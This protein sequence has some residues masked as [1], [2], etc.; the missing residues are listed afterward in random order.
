M[1]KLIL[2]IALVLFAST[3]LAAPVAPQMSYSLNGL[4]ITI[5]WTTVPDAATYTLHYAVYPYHAGDT[6]YSI[7][8]GNNTTFSIDLWDGAAYYIAVSAGNS[9]GNSGYSNI[10][11]FIIS[12]NIEPNFNL[13]ATSSYHYQKSDVYVD[14][15]DLVNTDDLF[16][17]HGYADFNQD[18]FTDVILAGGIFQE[19]IFS[20]VSLY[21]NDGS[22]NFTK[23]T[24]YI[25]DGFK[26]MQHP[27]KVIVGDYNNDSRM[28]A[29]IVGHGYDVEPYPGES[30]VLLL[31]TG[32]S[33]EVTIL[34]DHFS[35][36]H[37]ASSADIDNDGDIDIFTIDGFGES[38]FLIN[39]GTGSFE[40]TND[41]IDTYFHNKH[42][43]YTTELIDVDSDGYV[44][45]LVGGHEHGGATT[46]VLWGNNTGKYTLD[47]STPIP[48]V[49]D[50][51]IVVDFDA[52][53]ID[54]DGDRDLVLN[55]VAGGGK[56]EFYDGYYVQVL[57]NTGNRQF[58]DM[59]SSRITNGSAVSSEGQW[60]VG[61]WFLWITMEDIDNDGDLDITTQDDYVPYK[62]WENDGLGNF[63]LKQ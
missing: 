35:F 50:F 44:D 18:G 61:Q 39:D 27:R 7:N 9:Q 21:L 53:D 15:Y 57:E 26:G 49:S 36:F 37:G 22:N 46:Y 14:A 28:D 56:Y 16:F 48:T 62:F 55:R 4:N 58:A 34:S 63:S 23:D 45:L 29:Y 13:E 8:N 38:F 32:D 40:S 2:S 54:N 17:V 60:P 30:P 42:G 47:L 11:Y 33:F 19:E 24:A 5:D 31:S 3:S 52:E 12:S 59:T 20:P 51:A 43:Y 6:I 1:K 41:R 10:E 25:P